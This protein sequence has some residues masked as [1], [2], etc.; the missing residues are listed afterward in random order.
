M[1]YLNRVYSDLLMTRGLLMDGRR[2]LC[3]TLELAWRNN[4]VSLSC[5]PEGIY[6]V[7]KSNSTHHGQCFRFGS[8]RGRSG[9]LIHSGNSI[10]DTRGCILVGLDANDTN[11]LHSKPAMKRLY[12]ALPDNFELNVRNVENGM[13]R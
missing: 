2:P 4:E 10:R 8:V 3:H 7:C 13:A 5:I 6:D 9:I 12:D 1:I 11:V